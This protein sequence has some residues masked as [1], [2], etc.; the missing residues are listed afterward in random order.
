MVSIQLQLVAA[1]VEGVWQWRHHGLAAGRVAVALLERWQRQYSA[2][3]TDCSMIGRDEVMERI[4]NKET[5]TCSFDDLSNAAHRMLKAATQ[6][7]LTVACSQ[8]GL[9]ALMVHSAVR[10]SL[11]VGERVPLSLSGTWRGEHP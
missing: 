11:L 9:C 3:G 2:L 7:M 5:G 6:C 10:D 1:G 8:C 4:G